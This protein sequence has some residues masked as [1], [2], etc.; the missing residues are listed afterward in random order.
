MRINVRFFTVLREMTGRRT[1]DIVVRDDADVRDILELL[2]ERHGDKFRTY[3]FEGDKL[4]EH[5]HVLLDGV[6]VVTLNGLGTK[7]RD[8]ST[9]AIVPPV[10]GG[11]R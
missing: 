2:S 5:M 7:L 8:N 4:R 3:L 6:N 10:G 11:F 9:L 1:E